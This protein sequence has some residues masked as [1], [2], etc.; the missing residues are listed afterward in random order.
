MQQVLII[1]VGLIGATLAYRL[2]QAGAGVTLVEAQAQPA[3]QASGHSFGWINASYY[4]TPAHHHLRV[5]GIE[6]HHRLARDLGADLWDWQ[7]CLWAEDA[8]ALDQMAADLGPSP[9]PR[10]VLPSGKV[11]LIL[12]P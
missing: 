2:A 12:P 6:A 3:A 5:A 10:A 11:R 1:G 9:I 4:L 7:G 8:A